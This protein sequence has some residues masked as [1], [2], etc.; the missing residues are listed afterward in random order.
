M[1]Y[2]GISLIVLV[3]T[4]TSTYDETNKIDRIPPK[5]NIDKKVVSFFQIYYFF[6]Y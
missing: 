1:K 6:W 3:I 4:L 2:R 5:N